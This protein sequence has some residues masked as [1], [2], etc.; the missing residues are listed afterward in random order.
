MRA[1][2]PGCRA[3]WLLFPETQAAGGEQSLQIALEVI[4][5][6]AALAAAPGFRECPAKGQASQM[7]G[8]AVTGHGLIVVVATGKHASQLEQTDAVLLAFDVGDEVV[9]QATKEAERTSTAIWLAMGLASRIS[10][11]SPV[12]PA[13]SASHAVS[14]KAKLMTS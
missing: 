14:T 12:L 2:R 1:E 9:D 8:L 11:L 4:G 7:P 5:T 3:G 10:S 13:K 6:N